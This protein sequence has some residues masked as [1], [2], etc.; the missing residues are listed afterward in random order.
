MHRPNVA[1]VLDLITTL[2]LPEA[3]QVA[4]A[5]HAYIATVEAWQ[6][7]TPNVVEQIDAPGGCYRQ[8]LVKC[9][10]PGCKCARG[11]L[12]G[13]YWYGYTYKKGGGQSKRYIGKQ[14]PA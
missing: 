9:G 6:Q 1:Q 12:H 10:K 2:T 13:P 14:R 4:E 7:P 5:L 3:R 8:E 11:E